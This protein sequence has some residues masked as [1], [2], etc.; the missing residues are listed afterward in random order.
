MWERI[1]RVYFKPRDAFSA[2]FCPMF[3]AFLQTKRYS[4]QS[5]DR[6][7]PPPTNVERWNRQIR[8]R[9]LLISGHVLPRGL[10]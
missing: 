8:L 3:I 1:S 9:F 4:R 6:C 2:N 7:Q 10:A 5:I